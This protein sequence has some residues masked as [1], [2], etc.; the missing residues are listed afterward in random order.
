MSLLFDQNSS[1]RLVSRLRA[2]YPNSAHVSD[3]EMGVTDDHDIW[4]FAKNHGFVIASKD[5]DFLDLSATL[6]HPPKV[7]AIRRGNCSTSE[8]EAI[9]RFHY[10]DILGFYRD[11][12][13][14][15]LVMY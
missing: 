11:H 3:R 13:S 6:G 1:P 7:I 4:E 9:L 10:E 5:A 8:V 12:D 2:I 15:I 14:G